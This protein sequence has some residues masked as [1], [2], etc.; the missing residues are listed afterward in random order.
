MARSFE[1]GNKILIFFLLLSAQK[2][3]CFSYGK[4]TD[5]KNPCV[6]SFPLGIFILSSS[7]L[8]LHTESCC[9]QFIGSNGKT[10]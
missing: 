10:N 9:V 1:K 5:K 6:Y 4:E 3:S 2:L 7:Q 8:A